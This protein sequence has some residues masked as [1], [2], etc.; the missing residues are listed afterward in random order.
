MTI[1]PSD[2]VTGLLE[3]TA[4]VFQFLNCAR[5]HRDREIKGV[6]WH[7][8]FFYTAWSF[9]DVWYFAHLRQWCAWAGTFVILS[10]SLLWLTLAIRY[11]RGWDE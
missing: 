11:R 1:D 7:L 3:T 9:W 2:L 8:T 10:A 4:G 6:F 5:L